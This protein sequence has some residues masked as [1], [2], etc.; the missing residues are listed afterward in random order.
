MHRTALCQLALA[1]WLAAP[2]VAQGTFFA[3]PRLVRAELPPIPNPMIAGGGEVLVEV[4]VDIRGRATRPTVL[5][6]TPPYTQ[7]VL[8]AISRWQFQPAR[9]RDITGAE[10]AVDAPITVSAVYRSHELYNN[11]TL[12]EPP[13]DF[14]R[15]SA[16][17][18]YPL[19]FV[20][21]G[22]PA[23]ALFGSVLLYEVALDESGRIATARQVA[24]LVPGFEGVASEALGKMRFRAGAYRARPAPATTYVIFGFTLPN[25]PASQ[26]R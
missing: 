26:S 7:M 17:V 9:A 21:P 12:G 6:S 5:R 19:V 14:L 24:A 4:L 3:P 13:K 1:F 16:D 2:L 18:A 15:P 10:S 25:T 11:P 8:D 22:F 20:K 23:Q